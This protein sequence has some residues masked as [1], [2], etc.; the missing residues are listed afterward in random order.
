MRNGGAKGA[1]SKPRGESFSEIGYRVKQGGTSHRL[2]LDADFSLWNA[3]LTRGSAPKF[4][5]LSRS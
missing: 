2:S 4:Q 3:G 1:G 5:R